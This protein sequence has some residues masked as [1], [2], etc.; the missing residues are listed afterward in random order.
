MSMNDPLADMLTRIR[1]ASRARFQSV[2]M[3]LSALKADVA[4]VLKEEGFIEDYQVIKEGPQG[5]L[6]VQLK[7]GPHNE[8]L[9]LGSV[10]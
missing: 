3:P 2:E 8:Q 5:V 9:L 10:G 1:N 7:Y 6:K 4:K